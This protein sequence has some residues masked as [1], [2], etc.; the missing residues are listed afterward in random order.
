MVDQILI[1]I[2]NDL[3]LKLL[4]TDKNKPQNQE[5]RVNFLLVNCGDM[6]DLSRLVGAILG[7]LDEV[8]F[9]KKV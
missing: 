3:L 2:L 4:D 1:N 6:S 5:T 7:K 8:N 9:S